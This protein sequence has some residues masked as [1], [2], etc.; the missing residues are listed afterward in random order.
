VERRTRCTA[1]RGEVW[2]LSTGEGCAQSL[3]R[4]LA[5]K[6]ETRKLFSA[7]RVCIFF[8][9]DRYTRVGS[10]VLLGM[11]LTLS[12]LCGC[13]FP[14][15][16]KEASQRQLELLNQA[17]R[18][19]FNYQQ[20]FAA[21]ID[22]AS[23]RYVDGQAKAA[24]LKRSEELKR[25]KQPVSALSAKVQQ[26]MGE[27]KKKDES[28]EG[29]K[30]LQDMKAKNTKNYE[31]YRRYLQVT[32]AVHSLLNTYISTDVA[33]ESEDVEALKSAVKELAK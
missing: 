17:D 11:L 28:V 26:A 24:A 9:R 21:V 14:A 5:A 18:A 6:M 32:K 10:T 33:P 25:E 15:H 13:A 23:V 20:T 29:V 19:A 7:L 16:V 8:K 30:Q 12:L 4:P 31:D 2:E 27:A 1:R 22:A 3:S